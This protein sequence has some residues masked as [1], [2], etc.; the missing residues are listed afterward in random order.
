MRLLLPA[1]LL[2][3][4]AVG[5]AREVTR[6]GIAIAVPDGK[7]KHSTGTCTGDWGWHRKG[8]GFW[9]GTRR[10]LKEDAEYRS[11]GD[12]YDIHGFADIRSEVVA[13]MEPN[14]RL[15]KTEQKKT[16]DGSPVLVLEFEIEPGE[17]LPVRSWTIVAFRE[18]PDRQSALEVGCSFGE[19]QKVL[20]TQ[21]F[22]AALAS[23]CE[24]RAN[25][26]GIEARQK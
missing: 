1:A 16:Q 9:I 12:L 10:Y 21:I 25:G 20:G 6:D 2:L 13:R 7:W 19:K 22:Q 24:G 26:L 18:T 8:I 17:D 5:E 3:A 23:L 14:G 4:L 11:S 15:L